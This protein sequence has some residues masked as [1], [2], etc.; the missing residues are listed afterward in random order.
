M[1][2]LIGWLQAAC[3]AAAAAAAA[4]GCLCVCESKDPDY[5]EHETVQI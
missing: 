3:E 1:Y 4:A 5:R 2:G